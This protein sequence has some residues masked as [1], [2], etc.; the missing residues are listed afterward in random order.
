MA[1]CVASVAGA[2]A[3]PR[4]KF[5]VVAQIWR[6]S[7]TG[8]GYNLFLRRYIEVSSGSS[9][10]GTNLSTSWGNVLLYGAGNYLVRDDQLGT[11]G[12]GGT[13]SLGSGSIQAYYTGGSGTTYRSSTSISYTVPRPT[14]T[15][16]YDA[17]GGTG[18]PASQT[19][20]YGYILTL[21]KT[22]P[23][24]KGYEFLGWSANKNA[25]SPTYLP[26]GSYGA[27]ANITM[28]AVW[29][30]KGTMCL[31]QDGQTRKGRP[32]LYQNGEKRSGIP[33][34]NVNGTWKKGGA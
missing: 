4:S 1:D 15:V 28:Y 11:Y 7:D 10:N 22:I 14:H 2:W 30:R 27:D 25:T 13:Y 17:N 3:G 31:T 9:F 5:R 19:K 12:Y 24:R 34:L 6:N 20:T 29:K 8:S 21:S 33:W 26:G 18:A 32:W 23:T 16:T